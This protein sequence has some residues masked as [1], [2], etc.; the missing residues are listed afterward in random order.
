MRRFAQT[1]LRDLV[2]GRLTGRLDV[3][4]LVM[5]APLP[6]E[7]R[8]VVIDVVKRTRLWRWEKLDVADELVAH[9]ADGLA[10]GRA[11]ASLAAAFGSPRRAARLIRRAKKRARPFVWRA[12]GR[13]IQGV[14]VLIGAAMVVYVFAAIRLFSGEPVIAH[15]YLADINAKARAVP[16]ADRAWP[17][18]RACLLGLGELPES[19]E[20]WGSRLRPG[21]VGWD[22]IDAYLEANAATLGRVRAA[23]ARPG[24]GFVAGD[25]DAELWPEV[26]QASG[27]PR[28]IAGLVNALL[29][30]LVEIRRLSRLLALDA[31]RAAASG[32]GALVVRDVEA[33]LGLAEQVREAPFLL[34]ELVS[35]AQVTLAVK[36]LAEILA[37]HPEV[38]TDDQL[39]TLARRFGALYGGRFELRLDGER[40]LFQDLIQRVYSD[41]GHGDG[42]LTAEGIRSLWMAETAAAE[43]PDR[44]VGPL[45]PAL[46]LF[47]AG[48][49]E[50]TEEVT[51]WFDRA[52][53][54]IAKPLWQRDRATIDLELDELMRSRIRLARYFP[55]ALLMPA[56]TQAGVQP[57]LVRQ[58]RDA[59][60]AAIGL[61]SYRRRVGAWPA[62]LDELVPDFLPALPVDRFDGA[63]LRYR[64]FEGR[65]VLYSVGAD[66]DDDG[67]RPPQRPDGR[68]AQELAA[69]FVTGKAQAAD[70]DWVLW[71]QE[72]GLRD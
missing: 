42:H 22:E 50:M 70:G 7:L 16:D 31:H 38:L 36:T 47:M 54:E 72:K 13:C 68:F 35:F 59:L 48:R 71:G 25:V 32:D 23:A 60:S 18:Y 15:D 46:G 45:A 14:G 9:F 2:R 40:L 21:E 56:L 1:P 66:G 58:R 28:T 10:A 37:E 63:P 5:L 51:R 41:D 11:P 34:N 57:E 8:L 24:L 44:R 52:E 20:R 49:R 30:H 61:E 53:A 39:E 4:R 3:R 17:E 19:F 43:P 67:G 65:P 27:G 26:E 64:L 6:K 29:P 62:S 33:S 69:R 55:L 12:W